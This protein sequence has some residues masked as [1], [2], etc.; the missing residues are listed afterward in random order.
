[1]ITPA[2]LLG[3]TKAAEEYGRERRF[4]GPETFGRSDEDWATYREV[5]MFSGHVWEGGP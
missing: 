1:M 5:Q 2:N 3:V 4:R